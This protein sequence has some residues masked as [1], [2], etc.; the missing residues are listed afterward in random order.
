MTTE[1]ASVEHTNPNISTVFTYGPEFK[2]YSS[3]RKGY[4]YEM[5]VQS[6]L[7]KLGVLHESNPKQF[8]QW[9]EQHKEKPYDIK[10][11]LKDLGY[12]I[13][14]KLCLTPIFRSYFERDWSTRDAD[15]FVTND[16]NAIPKECKKQLKRR[17]QKLLDTTEFVKWVQKKLVQKPLT[18]RIFGYIKNY[19]YSIVR[20]RSNTVLNSLGINLITQRIRKLLSFGEKEDKLSGDHGP[21]NDEKY[22]NRNRCNKDKLNIFSFSV[23]STQPF[24]GLISC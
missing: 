3:F 18:N 12:K 17:G 14:C 13:E 24:Y 19:F 15:I 11:K 5:H 9:K 10:A 4:S 1:I 6:L 21:Q 2:H 16:K 20:T 23:L 7:D 8:E 22:K